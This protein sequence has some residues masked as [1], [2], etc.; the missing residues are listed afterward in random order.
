M[1]KR[2]A[3]KGKAAVSQ[4]VQ[5]KAPVQARIARGACKYHISGQPI[6][7]PLPLA[8]TRGDLL[9]LHNA[10]LSI[11]EQLKSEKYPMYPLFAV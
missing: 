10:I 1:R 6:L 8:H 3:K 11:E 9:E 7:T 4:P 5:K 2:P